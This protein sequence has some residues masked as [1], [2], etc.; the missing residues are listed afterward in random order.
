MSMRH[1]NKSLVLAG[2]AALALGAC[3][4]KKSETTTTSTTTTTTTTAA[5]AGPIDANSLPKRKPGLWEQ[6]IS[7]DGS[8]PMVMKICLD[9]ATD[10]QLSMAGAQASKDACSENK[11]TRSGDG[12]TVNATCNM[13][14][15][16]KVVSTGTIKGDFQSAYEVAVNSTTSGASVPQMN[17]ASAVKISA[18][19]VG[20]CPEGMAPGDQQMPNGMVI[21]LSQFD[22]AKARALA[23]EAAAGAK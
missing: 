5:A 8:A 22:P 21:N 17:R 16:G 2:V 7:A 23:K 11:I 4:N 10:A 14:S 18:K 6:S 13:G 9:A 1:L 20:A 15:G 12:F 3:D 19:W